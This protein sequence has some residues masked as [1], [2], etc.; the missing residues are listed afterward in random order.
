M[1]QNKEKVNFQWPYKRKNYVLFAIG[2]FVIIVGYLIMYLGK[3]DSFQSLTLSPILLLI[4]YLIII[5]YALLYRN[6]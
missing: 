1:S 5:P 6:N 4:G 3:V 2:V